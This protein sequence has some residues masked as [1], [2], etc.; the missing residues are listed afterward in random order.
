M[1]VEGVAKDWVSAR[2]H[3]RARLFAVCS[4]R[5]LEVVAS[6]MATSP[7]PSRRYACGHARLE[8]QE[9]EDLASVRAVQ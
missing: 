4:S 3:A 2:A 1:K 5:I 7:S 6:E 9:E 8:E